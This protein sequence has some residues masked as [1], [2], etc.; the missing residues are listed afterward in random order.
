MRRPA[1]TIPLNAARV[2]RSGYVSLGALMSALGT[3]GK[4]YVSGVRLLDGKEKNRVKAVV[5]L[6][7]GLKARY[8]AEGIRA[9]LA[10]PRTYEGATGSMTFDGSGDPMRSLYVLR[11]EGGEAQFHMAVEM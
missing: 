3:D 9:A 4:P 10:T 11:L 1:I 6:P 7:N 8:E 5:E 2:E